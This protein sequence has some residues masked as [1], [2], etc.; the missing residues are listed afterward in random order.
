MVW[1][2]LVGACEMAHLVY[3][4]NPGANVR[5]SAWRWLIPQVTVGRGS[6]L[7]V[8]MADVNADGRDEIF[9]ANKGFA[10]VV[11]LS[12]GNRP[13]NATSMF[14]VVGDAL[15][16]ES[17]R[18]QVLLRDGISN[19]A[20]VSRYRRRWRS[21][22]A[23]SQPASIP[24]HATAQHRRASGTAIPTVPNVPCTRFRTYPVSGEVFP[25]LSTPC[26]Q[27]LMVMDE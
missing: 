2:D 17:W 9:A 15:N 19:Q 11:R 4:Q 1:P 18:E 7:R 3:L 14:R 16:S 20:I 27:M 25:T 6:W 22:R 23:R 13:D 12:V 5:D 21:G 8:S 24:A 26:S 10:D